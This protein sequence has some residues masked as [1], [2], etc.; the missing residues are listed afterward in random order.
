[1]FSCSLLV[2]LNCYKTNCLQGP[3]GP[4]GTR[5][6]RGLQVGENKESCIWEN[7]HLNKINADHVYEM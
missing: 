6:T 5:G 4:V 7:P 2:L 1:M 3:E